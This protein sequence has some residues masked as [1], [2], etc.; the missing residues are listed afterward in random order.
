VHLVLS[1]DKEQRVISLT[2]KY[3]AARMKE[4]AA[5][6]RADSS[7][8]DA[9]AARESE[10]LLRSRLQ[11]ADAELARLRAELGAAQAAAAAAAAEQQDA[12]TGREATLAGLQD[13]EERLTEQGAELEA[14]RARASDAEHALLAARASLSRAH[15]DAE[16]WA[17]FPKWLALADQ[18]T[19]QVGTRSSD[20]ECTNPMFMSACRAMEKV[21]EEMHAEFAVE[22]ELLLKHVELVKEAHQQALQQAE[23][24]LEQV[25]RNTSQA[26][27]ARPSQEDLVKVLGL[28]VHAPSPLNKSADYPSVSSA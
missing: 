16:R 8:K 13:A 20:N 23:A 17:L 9:A 28:Y 25:K 6:R 2:A 12:R 24:E 3:T 7:A 15:S 11:A 5:A 10:Q 14:A 26:L 18:S 22:R 4:T 21:K 27:A 19:L 1:G